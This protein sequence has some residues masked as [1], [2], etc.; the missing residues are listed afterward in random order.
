MPHYWLYRRSADQDCTLKLRVNPKKSKLP[1]IF[2]NL[3]G[4]DSHFIMQEIGTIG[5]EHDLEINSIPNNM[6]KYMAFMLGKHL[7]F[8]DSFHFTADSLEQLADNLPANKFKYTSQV[9]QDEEL[10]L[11]K[12]KGVYPHD[13]MDSFQMFGDHQLP[14]KDS[15]SK[16]KICDNRQHFVN[17]IIKDMM[18]IP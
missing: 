7:V 18:S 12:K 4:Y 10:A 1:V 14:P 9:F 6:E 8:M 13:Y 2:H 3:C 15:F 16:F 11:M 5:K 17:I